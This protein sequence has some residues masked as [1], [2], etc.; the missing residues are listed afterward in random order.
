M[1]EPVSDPHVL[2]P[3]P[4]TG[5][6]WG[7]VAPEGADTALGVAARL[8]AY[9]WAEQQVFG[10]LGG[11]ITEIAEPDVK[12]AVAEHA[13]HAA[14]R[15]QRW[16]ELLPT[17]PPGADVLVAPPAGLAPAMAVAAGLAAGPDRT[18]EKLTIAH[19]VLL[20]RLAGALRAHL[21]WSPA[22]SEPAVRRML[23]IVSHVLPEEPPPELAAMLREQG[24]KVPFAQEALK[25]AP[26]TRSEPAGNA[27]GRVR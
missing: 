7:A 24:T 8:G 20:P 17:A 26:E 6:S 27:G 23:A 12:L 22:V 13:D 19:R 21:D 9:C 14:W 5:S 25:Q 16:Y 1:P 15:A 18:I 10:L 4:V 3:R 2:A 11:W